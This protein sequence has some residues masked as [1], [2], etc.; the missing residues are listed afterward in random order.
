MLSAAAG[1]GI[2][3][4]DAEPAGRVVAADGLSDDLLSNG[5][6]GWL[7]AGLSGKGALANGAAAVAIGCLSEL[8]AN[9]VTVPSSSMRTASSAPTRLKLS[10]RICPL[11]RLK[12]ETR[13]PAFG[14][15]ATTVPSGSRT[16]M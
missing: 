6:C 12:P 5:A 15:L 9:T 13:I 8:D 7:V 16:T 4:C 2:A 1:C 11:S 3:A 10:A 14:A